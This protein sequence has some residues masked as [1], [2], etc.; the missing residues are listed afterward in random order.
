MTASPAGEDQQ[1]FEELLRKHTER[2]SLNNGQGFVS[3][4]RVVSQESE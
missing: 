2:A 4:A 1:R 3:Y